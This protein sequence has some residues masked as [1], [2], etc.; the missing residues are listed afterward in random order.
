MGDIP[1][2]KALVERLKDAPFALLGV[3]T[4]DD[5]ETY[6]RKAVEYGVTW[7]SAWQGSTRGPIPSTWGV[8]SY[9]TI[10]VLD[11]DHVIRFIDARGQ[12]L[13]NKVDL[14]LAELTDE[15]LVD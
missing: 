7:R 11:A 8:N 3:N 13:S 10:F 14:L 2:S 4:D 12:E 5:K 6:Q 1:H 9:P 15:E